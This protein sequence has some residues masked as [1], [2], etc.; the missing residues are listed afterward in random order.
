MDV[1]REEGHTGMTAMEAQRRFE[2]LPADGAPQCAIQFPV[3]TQ[4]GQWTHQA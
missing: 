1:H 4:Q 3:R 2:E